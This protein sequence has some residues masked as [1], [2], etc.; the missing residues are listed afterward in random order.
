MLQMFQDLIQFSEL[1]FPLFF[2][3]GKGK[4]DLL[5]G[6]ESLLASKVKGSISVLRSVTVTSHSFTFSLFAQRCA[7]SAST[8]LCSERSILFPSTTI[9]T[10][11]KTMGRPHW[12]TVEGTKKNCSSTWQS[13][14]SQLLWSWGRRIESSKGNLVRACQKQ[15]LKTKRLGM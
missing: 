6:W 5:W 8:C 1:E 15:S 4:L 9:A 13:Q 11:G 10:W 3:P 2:L 14:S 12:D 7:T